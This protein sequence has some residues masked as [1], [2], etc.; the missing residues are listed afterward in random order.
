MLILNRRTGET[1]HIGDDIVITV[2]RVIDGTVRIGIEAPKSVPVHRG[3]IYARIK[4][5]KAVGALEAAGK[6]NL[7]RGGPPR[8]LGGYEEATVETGS[9]IS[10]K[11]RPILSLGLRGAAK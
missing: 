4:L 9:S 10:Q 5:E 6:E 3:E 2:S 1:I 7:R 8:R 11:N